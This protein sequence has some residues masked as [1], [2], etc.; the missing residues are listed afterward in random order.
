ML[1]RTRSPL[2]RAGGHGGTA[3]TRGER[4]GLFHSQAN[5][6]FVGVVRP[7]LPVPT[8][9]IHDFVSV[10]EIGAGTGAPPLQWGDK[11]LLKV[12]PYSPS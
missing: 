9:P 5:H 11:T 10:S 1:H 8:L 6:R 3:P 7:L 12:N 4:A 2:K